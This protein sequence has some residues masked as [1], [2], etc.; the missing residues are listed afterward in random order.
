MCARQ[1]HKPLLGL[2]WLV[3]LLFLKL[4]SCF[5]KQKSRQSDP[6]WAAVS[7]IAQETNL[8]LYIDQMLLQILKGFFWNKHEAIAL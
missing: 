3:C 4:F 7:W 6:L 2:C 8:R 1:W 5:V